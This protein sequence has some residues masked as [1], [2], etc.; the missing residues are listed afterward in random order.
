LVEASSGK[1]PVWK[2]NITYYKNIT[3]NLR[4]TGCDNVNRNML[5]W[6]IKPCGFADRYQRF[7]EH[8]AFI[9]RTSALKIGAVCDISSSHSG[10]HEAG[11]LHRAVS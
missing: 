9:F 1:G 11:L 7:E 8:T 3:K 6:V 5:F 10:E 4:E 2:E